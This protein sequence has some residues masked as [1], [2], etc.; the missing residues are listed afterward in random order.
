MLR[1]IDSSR[2]EFQA[3][4]ARPWHNISFLRPT[5]RARLA[6]VALLAIICFMALRVVAEDRPE[7]SIVLRELSKALG[8]SSNSAD[9]SEIAGQANHA[10]W[11][12]PDRH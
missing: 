4:S 10:T 2:S 8:R 3:G 7:G 9:R 1:N 11:E 6:V 12:V 5:P